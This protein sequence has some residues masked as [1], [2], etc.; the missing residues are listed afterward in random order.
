MS[1]Q[2]QI[3]RITA[4]KGIIREKLV[5]L[6]LATSTDNLD[7]LAQA[8]NGIE[9]R[10]AVQGKVKEG[11]SFTIPAGYH[12]GSGVVEG[13]GGGGDYTLQAKTVTP[14]KQAQSVTS[15]EG[16]YGLSSVTVNPIPDNYQD[17]SSTTATADQVL[18]TKL[19]VAADGTLTAGTMPNIGAVS[20]SINGLE[21]TG[22]AIPKGYHDGTGVVVLSD[23]IEN[24]LAAI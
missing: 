6:G 20:A 16:Y 10:G 11:E 17:V 8:I 9:N 7:T 1:I 23:S 19:F 22:Y 13:V 4:D 24:A 2:T 3:T 12:N 18:A 15:D 21:V 5:N 14:T